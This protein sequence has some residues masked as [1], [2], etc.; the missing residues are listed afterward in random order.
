M[1]DMAQ[2]W[3]NATQ[4]MTTMMAAMPRSGKRHE[5]VGCSFANFFRHN[6][7]VFDGSDGPL[8]PNNWITNF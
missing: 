7:L 1:L 5:T 3:A 4:F 8:A 6:S 2:F